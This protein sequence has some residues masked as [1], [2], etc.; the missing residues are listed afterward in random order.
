M[1]SLPY[2][3]HWVDENDIDAVCEVLRGDWLTTGPVVDEFEQALAQLVHA[4][5]AVAV[6]SGTAA[7]HTAYVAAG[8][9]AGDAIITSPLTFVATASA[10]LHLGAS[11]SFA[12]IDPRTGNLD[13]AAA[14]DLVDSSTKLLVPTDYAGQPADYAGLMELARHCDLQVVA[15]AAHSLGATFH[16]Q[17]VGSIADATATSFHPVKLITTAEGGAMLTDNAGWKRRANEFRNHGIVRE[18]ANF[19]GNGDAWYYEVQR[20]GFNYRIPDLLCALGLSQLRKMQQFL[21]RRREIAARYGESFATSTAL[22]LPFVAADVEPAWHL[23]VIRL[24]DSTSRKRVF[25]HLQAHGLGVQLHYIPVYRH[26][27]FQDMGFKDGCCPKAEDFSARAISLPIFPA[28]TN[29]DVD[30]VIETVLDAAAQF[31]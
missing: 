3:R 21:D 6:N 11:V 12:D 10:A 27:A 23:Y 30:R 8:L 31:T 9:R 7:L 24:P 18:A 19:R 22:E 5:Y 28:M 2:G 4:Q 17:P 25:D 1:E 16:G 13:V 20:L 14:G 15:D 29:S 26:P